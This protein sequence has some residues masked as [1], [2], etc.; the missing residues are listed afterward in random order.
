MKPNILFLA[1]LSHPATAVAEHIK[2]IQGKGCCWHLHNPLCHKILDKLDFN[3]FDAIG[4]HYSIKPTQWYYLSH[5]LKQKISSFQGL[6]FL[7]LQDEYQRVDQIQEFMND[8]T[9]KLLF[10]LVKEESLPQAYPK[11]SGLIKIPILTAYA[12]EAM[13]TMTH[14]PIADRTI[15]V[16]YRSRR[17]PY[18]LGRLAYEK[19]FIATEFVKRS[20]SYGLNLDISVEES[21]RVY[22]EQWFNLLSNSKAVLGSESGASIWD[23]D[24]SIEKQTKKYQAK[25][26]QASF[27][28]VHAAILSPYEGNLR[29]NAISPRLFEAAATK[30]P[31]IMFPGEYNGICEAGKHYI[32]LEKDFSNLPKIMQQLS[33]LDYLQSI[34]DQAYTDLIASNHY[35]ERH[36]ATLVEQTLL[37]LIPANSRRPP[38]TEIQAAFK[39]TLSRYK[40]LN[41]WRCLSTELRFMIKQAWILICSPQ[42]NMKTRLNSLYKGMHRYLTYVGA[43]RRDGSK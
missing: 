8:A 24:G 35:S 10:T 27:E 37:E 21:D 42:K 16:S 20:S 33:D 3:Q 7:F 32:P 5:A 18:W 34:A 23:K 40:I 12:S 11:L 26:P 39:K 41:Q 15:D 30:T 4:L 17:S 19:E 38:A 22:A 28:E 25:H 1:D 9:F 43:R 29:Y 6:K 31:M 13:K 36:L 14:V 2:A